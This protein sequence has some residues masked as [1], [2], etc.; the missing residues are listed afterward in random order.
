M[1]ALGAPVAYRRIACGTEGGKF[2]NGLTDNL[3]ANAFAGIAGTTSTETTP[4]MAVAPGV[5]QLLPNHLYPRPWLV[6]KTVRMV[7]QR[8]E[9]RDLL[10]L[11]AGDPYDFYRD[12]QSWYRMIDPGLADPGGLYREEP[13]GVVAAIERAIGEAERFHKTV[14]VT[15]NGSSGEATPYYH[16]HTFAF[17]GA[18]NTLKTYSKIQWL[19]LI[20]I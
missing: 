6:I 16:P 8:E 11:P 13:G 10:R 3:K 12:M 4:V 9:I 5:M 17:Y 2:S 19:S 1:P 18:D 7:N 15:G 20:H 14:L